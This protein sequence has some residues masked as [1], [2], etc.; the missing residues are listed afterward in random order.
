MHTG[1]LIGPGKWIQREQCQT[2][3]P[4]RISNAHGNDLEGAHKAIYELRTKQM[5]LLVSSSN[6]L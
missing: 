4:T 6:C 2:I 5:M 3:H 1:R